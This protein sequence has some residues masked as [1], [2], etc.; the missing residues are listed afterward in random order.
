M[1]MGWTVVPVPLRKSGRGAAEYMPFQ[2]YEG[3]CAMPFIHVYAK[4]GRDDETKKKAAQAIIKAASETM[5]TPENLFTLAYEEIESDDWG[6][7]VKEAIVE[8]LRDKLLI[9]SGKPV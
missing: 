7:K 4:S 8:P 6:K 3:G 1:K 9:E 5:G 2:Q